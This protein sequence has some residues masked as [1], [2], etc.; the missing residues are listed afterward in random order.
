MDGQSRLDAVLGLCAL[1]H[2]LLVRAAHE[3][4]G[5]PADPEVLTQSSYRAGRDGLRATLLHGGALRPVPEVARDALA[6]ARPY[7]AGAEDAFE[8][9]ERILA[10]GNGADRMRAAYERGGF[11]E[12]LAQLA[13]DTE[14]PLSRTAS[15]AARS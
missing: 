5:P 12:V 10:E 8:E 6:R 9:V 13:A 2:A 14:A 3:D 11:T 1:A 4:D 15:G 7:A